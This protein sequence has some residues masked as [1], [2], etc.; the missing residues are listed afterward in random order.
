MRMKDFVDVKKLQA[1]Q[2]QFSDATG[3]AAIAVDSDGSYITKGSNFTDFCMKYTR[4]CE[5]GLRR[6]VKCDNECT[7][8]Y[9][10]HAGLMDFASD[11]IINGERVGAIIGGQVL[12]HEPDEEGFRKIARELG[13]DERAYLEALKKV[14]I[15][16]E[17]RIRAAA[18]ML[19]NVFNELVNLE[20]LKSITQKK[21]QVFDQEVSTAVSSIQSIKSN[22]RNLE[23][24]ST[25][26]KILS[27]NASIEASRAGQAGVGFAVVAQEFGDLSIS[28]AKVYDEIR[29]SISVIEKAIL[30]M[31][32]VDL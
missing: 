15:R 25:M 21:V 1:I 9:F 5:E 11:I 20:Y 18:E 8:T 3:L 7:G 26:E 4:G 29:G 2:D 17:K 27:I 28:S 16:S 10:C 13:I 32:K 14:P 19:G 31:Q 30:N 24:V 23:Q 12:P 6:C 22:M